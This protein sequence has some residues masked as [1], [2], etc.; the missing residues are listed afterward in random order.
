MRTEKTFFNTLISFTELEN[1][2]AFDAELNISMLVK[3]IFL[4]N[5]PF[6]QNVTRFF[7]G[8]LISLTILKL[9]TQILF[10]PTFFKRHL[11]LKRKSILVNEN[12]TKFCIFN[13]LSGRIRI[14]IMPKSDHKIKTQTNN[15][16][17]SLAFHLLGIIINVDNT[18]SWI[19]VTGLPNEPLWD[20]LY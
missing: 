9:F 4:R 11:T 8:Q 7:L 16:R 3:N 10:V 12:E 5:N 19:S 2:N 6:M 14:H 13:N 18:S 17:W 20:V 15:F 1:L